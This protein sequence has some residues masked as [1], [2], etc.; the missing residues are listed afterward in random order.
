[1]STKETSCSF[2]VRAAKRHGAKGMTALVD[3]A[4]SMLLPGKTMVIFKA[5]LLAGMS[6]FGLFY[7]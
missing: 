3:L 2:G 4:V 7:H 6:V 5:G 1:M